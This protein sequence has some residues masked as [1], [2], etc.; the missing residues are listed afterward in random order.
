MLWAADWKTPKKAD[1][2]SVMYAKE[3]RM[4]TMSHSFFFL[5]FIFKK[6]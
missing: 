1:G 3:D 5:S 6:W 2:S 4:E